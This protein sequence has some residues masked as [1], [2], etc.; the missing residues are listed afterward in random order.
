MARNVVM[1]ARRKLSGEERITFVSFETNFHFTRATTKNVVLT[2][3]S[4]NEEGEEADDERRFASRNSE[5]HSHFLAYVCV[6]MYRLSY[7]RVR[8]GLSHL[9]RFLVQFPQPIR[10]PRVAT[11]WQKGKR[12]KVK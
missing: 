12:Q 3:S 9:A 8:F 5:R 2:V 10:V 7:V 4:M 11:D 6:C 1:F